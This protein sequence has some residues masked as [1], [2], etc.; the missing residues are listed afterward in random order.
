MS[1]WPYC[2]P[3]SPLLAYN[4]WDLSILS[5]SGTSLDPEAMLCVPQMR[6]NLHKLDLL[7]AGLVPLTLS[8]GLSSE[9]PSFG[10]TLLTPLGGSV[11]SHILLY[12]P[13]SHP[14]RSACASPAQL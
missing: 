1:T 7:S 12:F 13:H 6:L 2:W 11:G 4:L 9:A 10:R 5:A 3:P 8:S 14:D